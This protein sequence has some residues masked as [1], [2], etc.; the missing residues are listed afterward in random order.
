MLDFIVQNARYALIAIGMLTVGLG[1]T[2][3]ADVDQAI[4]LTTTAIGGV[5]AAGA[6]IWGLYV[7]WNTKAVPLATAARVDVPTVSSVTGEKET[8][9]TFKG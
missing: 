3:Q 1:W 7:K 9:E 5:A 8:G 2:T 4:N 6:W